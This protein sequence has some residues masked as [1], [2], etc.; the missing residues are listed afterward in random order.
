MMRLLITRTTL[1]GITLGC[2]LLAPASAIAQP[3]L[4][5]CRPSKNCNAANK[6]CQ[7]VL[8]AGETAF[9]RGSPYAVAPK[10]GKSSIRVRL[11]TGVSQ[12]CSAGIRNQNVQVYARNSR[13][14]V[15]QVNLSTRHTTD[16]GGNTGLPVH[17]VFAVVCT[18][19]SGSCRFAW[20]HCRHQ[21]PLRAR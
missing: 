6:P 11:C 4:I 2:A 5:D 14:Y 13:R 3:K 21:L 18:N 19:I 10:I 9:L 1:A 8:G 12:T 16:T 20:Q 15:Y 17:T 7:R